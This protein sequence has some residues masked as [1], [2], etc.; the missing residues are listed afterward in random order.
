MRLFMGYLLGLNQSRPDAGV[1]VRLRSRSLRA[2]ERPRRRWRRT[3]APRHEPPAECR[4]PA[5]AETDVLDHGPS[6]A[7]AEGDAEDADAARAG[8]A[9]NVAPGGD[10]RG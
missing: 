5:P 9:A 1:N 6:G 7:V 3:P 2:S 8:E 10:A 4:V